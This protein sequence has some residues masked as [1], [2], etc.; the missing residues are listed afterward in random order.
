MNYEVNKNTNNAYDYVTAVRTFYDGYWFCFASRRRQL[1]PVK[2]RA[3]WIYYFFLLDEVEYTFDI[4]GAQ[5]FPHDELKY[6]I[7]TKHNHSVYNISRLSFPI[8]DDTINASDVQIHVQPAASLT[9]Q[10][11]DLISKSMPLPQPFLVNG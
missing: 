8:M 6:S 5:I 2:R 7:L 10:R 11:H 3:C 4:C 9:V 1:S